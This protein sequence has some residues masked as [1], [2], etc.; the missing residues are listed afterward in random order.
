[1]IA[2]LNPGFGDVDQDASDAMVQG[3]LER[4]RA[5]LACFLLSSMCV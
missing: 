2:S 1:M 3:F 4:Q 5:V